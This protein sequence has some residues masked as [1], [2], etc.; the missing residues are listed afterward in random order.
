MAKKCLIVYS[1]FT[2][3]TEKVAMRFKST[4]E[5]H[6]WECDTFKVRKR[7]GD[8][9]DPPFDIRTY[10]LACI[11]SGVILHLPYNEI[12]NFLRRLWLGIDP[13]IAL[14][15]RDETISYIQTPLPEVPRPQN[16]PGVLR[17][18]HK[19]VLGPESKKALIFVTYSGYEFGP[20]EA[21][22]AMDLMALEIEHS[23]FRCIGKFCCPGRFLNNPTPDTFHGDIR[24]RPDEK[25]LLEAE[26]F[27]EE[28]LGEIET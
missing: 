3:N 17:Y 28:K 15:D 9:L 14:R 1:S 25:D 18:H 26:K 11:G 8:I 12:L 13:R 20:R 7:A 5:R 21:E 19:I 6:G 22:P 4:L 16:D 27:I 23:N 2:G 24:S 10:D